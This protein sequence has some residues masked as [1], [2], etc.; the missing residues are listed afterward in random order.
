MCYN[1]PTVA[2]ATKK[3]NNSNTTSRKYLYP[4]IFYLC[5][6]EYGFTNICCYATVNLQVC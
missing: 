5:M 6:N 3:T 4:A 1:K 2:S